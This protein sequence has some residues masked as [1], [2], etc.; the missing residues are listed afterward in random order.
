MHIIQQHILKE[1]TL[2]GTARY[3][4]IKPNGVEGNQFMYHL[5]KLLTK[6][7]VL[8]GQGRYRLSATGKQYA[9]RVSMETFHPRVQPKVMTLIV[10]KNKRGEVLV[11]RRHR[12]PF[13]GRVGY[14]HGKV[15]LGEKIV[16]S[17]RRELQEKTGVTADVVYRGHAYST[18][19]END[20]LL[21]HDLVHIFDGKNPRGEVV[22]V[23]MAIG[24][25]FWVDPRGIDE[26]EYLPNFKDILT[27][28]EK[29]GKGLFF[30][31]FIVNE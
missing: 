7:Y 9:S 30:E 24:E 3:S 28:I 16:D 18:V 10:C 31:E 29:K 11:Y 6:G 22:N 23:N 17:A 21:V 8:K 13:R 27:L 20:E 26:E 15:H 4:D 25:A 2:R 5:K 14:P 19:Y 1:L 12:E